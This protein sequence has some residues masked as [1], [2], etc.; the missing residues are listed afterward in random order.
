M[1]RLA[2][3]L[4]FIV[5]PVLELVLLIKTG[6]AIGVWA[7]LGLVVAAAL[8]G[9]VVISRQSSTVV[10]RTLEAMSEGHAPVAGVL[11]SLFLL[12]AGLLL[13]TPGFVTDL[14]AIILLV[15]PLRR[16]IARWSMR[17]VLQRVDADGH[18]AAGGDGRARHHRGRR[19][20]DGPVIDG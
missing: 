7:T 15:P 10:Q 1:L 19:V 18:Q 12:L 5:M 9:A 3:G 8:A 20:Q 4:F 17:A 2:V 16:V 14:L 13:L 6:Q 11:D